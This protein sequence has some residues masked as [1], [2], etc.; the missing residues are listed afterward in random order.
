[1]KS[2]SIL[3]EPFKG[4]E[5]F[6][7]LIV[8]AFYLT[9]VFAVLFVAAAFAVKK[10]NREKLPDYF[11]GCKFFAI[12]YA[13][14]FAV[15]MAVLKMSDIV[16]AGEFYP[17]LFWPIAAVL[18]TALALFAA[19][20]LI[21]VAKPEF[22]PK[23]KFIALIII[24]I[25]VIVSIVMLALYYKTVAEYYKDV[26]QAGLYVSAVLLLLVLILGSSFLSKTKSK[27]MTTREL[28]YAAICIAM[29][30]ALS[31]IRFFTLPQSGSITLA[32]MLPIMLF[33]YMFGIKKGVVVG[34]IYGLLQAVQDPWIIHPAQFFLD[35]PIAFGMI[36]F[37]GLFHELGFFKKKP[38]VA[39]SLGATVAVS[40]RYLCHAL[41]GIFA[42]ATYA[43]DNGYSAVAWGF[44]YNTFTFAD[45]AIVLVVGV[46]MFASNAFV[47]MIDEK[48]TLSA[49][50]MPAP[51]AD[52]KIENK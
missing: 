14:A 33:S 49:E 26:S 5:S 40:L 12:G 42:F 31:Y 35:Y 52:V 18:I 1:M 15:M 24:L 47:R 3:S 45:L 13:V 10:L 7:K 21:S 17:S 9:I 50:L 2:E 46:M 39:F 41:S 37:T 28:A 6:D 19:G 34:L 38:I 44:L 36:G 4:L 30:F 29:S 23:Y 20:Y 22:L 11:K 43:Y 16:A 27:Q 25:P 32:S 48:S 51:E 8:I